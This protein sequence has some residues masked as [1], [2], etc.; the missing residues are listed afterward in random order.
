MSAKK[1]FLAAMAQQSNLYGLCHIIKSEKSSKQQSKIITVK[2]ATD[3]KNLTSYQ[4]VK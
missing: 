1:S 2:N 3:P 4:D